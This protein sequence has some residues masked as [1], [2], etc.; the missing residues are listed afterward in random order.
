M[1][2]GDKVKC[3]GERIRYTIQA[4]DDRFVIMTKP[5][6]LRKGKYLYSIV[7]LERGVRGRDNLVFG[8]FERYDTKKGAKENLKMLQEGEMEVSY[9]HYKKLEPEE[10]EQLTL[11]NK[12]IN[13]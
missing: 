13:L 9:R 4:R 6:N 1:K 2:V 7:D 3:V 12:D 11:L 5:F 8:S 10:I